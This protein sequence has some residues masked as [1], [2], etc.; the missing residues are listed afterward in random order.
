MFV[1]HKEVG[2]VVAPARV[3]RLSEAIRIGARIR[4]QCAGQFFDGDASCAIGAALEAV[5]GTNNYYADHV[6]APDRVWPEVRDLWSRIY[7]MNDSGKTREEI[8]DWLECEGY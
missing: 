6:Q 3:L 8:A 4:P 2:E 7:D 5:F 1:E